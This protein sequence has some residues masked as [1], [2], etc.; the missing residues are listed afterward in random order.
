MNG[1]KYLKFYPW[2]QPFRRLRQLDS[3]KRPSNHRCF[4]SVRYRRICCP[5]D[6]IL[7]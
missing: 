1:E 3:I 5:C 6:F 2:M 4:E 7:S